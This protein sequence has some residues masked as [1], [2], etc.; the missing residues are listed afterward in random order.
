M[1]LIRFT[2]PDVRITQIAAAA[3]GWLV[4]AFNLGLMV[5]CRTETRQ[6]WLTTF[7]DG[8]PVPGAITNA[9]TAG[10]DDSGHSLLP[11][12]AS[13]PA[14][15]STVARIKLIIHPPYSEHNCNA[16]HESRYSVR[17]KDAQKLVCFACHDDFL[18][19]AKF[20]HSPVEEGSCTT[21]HNP[22]ESGV[23]KLLVK[24]V[25]ALCN[26]CHDDVIGTSKFR[27]SPAES[28][29]CLVCHSAH[30]SQ[31]EKL[32][33][34]RGQAL[35]YECHDKDDVAKIPAHDKL[36]EK[37]CWSCHDPHGS[38]RA[39]LLKSVLPGGDKP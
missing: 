33:T 7:F 13:V 3:F 20:K 11:P 14:D 5:G 28:G 22:H 21:C 30:H 29:E 27:H 6:K 37:P 10:Y 8:V 36:D 23:A 32:L 16:C 1:G 9:A 19:K 38:D 31:E 34:R 15:T 35:C 25:P 24:A 2:M 26:D 12:T 17:M 39:G 18:A 4:I